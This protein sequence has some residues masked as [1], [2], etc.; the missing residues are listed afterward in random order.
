M[1][2]PQIAGQA[3]K[4]FDVML[5]ADDAHALMLLDQGIINDDEARKLLIFSR[6]LSIQG[7]KHF[8]FTADKEDLYLNIEALL[9]DK[10]GDYVGGKLHTGRSRND[11]YATIQRISAGTRS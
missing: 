6:E 1:L 3:D 5:K 11:L 4:F 8:K 7:G 9:I 2:E 10:L